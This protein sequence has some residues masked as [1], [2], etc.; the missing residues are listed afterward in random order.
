[1]LPQDQWDLGGDQE[2]ALGQ[3]SAAA[4]AAQPFLPTREQ[5]RQ[6]SVGPGVQ[7]D[8]VLATDIRRREEQFDR[9][10]ESILSG[11]HLDSVPQDREEFLQQLHGALQPQEEFRGGQLAAYAPVWQRLAA[12]TPPGE[13]AERANKVLRWMQQGAPLQFVDAHDKGKQHEPNHMRK[14]AGVARALAQAGYSPGQVETAMAGDFP[15]P[16]VLGNRLPDERSRSFAREQ[17]EKSRRLGV[18]A[19]WPEEWRRKGLRPYLLLPL[20][21]AEDAYGKRRLIFDARYLN[22]FLAYLAFCYDLLMRLLARTRRG[23][24]IVTDDLLSG[25]YQMWMHPDH[26][27]LL[28]FELDNEWFVFKC[29]PFG[30]SQCPW[31]FEQVLGAVYQLP[32]SVDWPLVGVVDDGGQT[33]PPRQLAQRSWAIAM[34]KAALG[35]VHN[36]EKSALWP[37]PALKLLGFVVDTQR[38]EL[39]V[40]ERKLARFERDVQQLMRTG[41]E[42]L[43]ASLRGQLAGF[44][45]AVRMAPLL[46]RWLQ[47]ASRGELQTTDWGSEFMQFWA[48]QLPRSNGKTWLPEQP[49]AI[50][51]DVWSDASETGYGAHALDGS[52]ELCQPFSLPE[53]CR[54]DSGGF[55]STEREVRGFLA[56]LCALARSHPGRVK[57]ADV[58][59]WG[60]SKGAVSDCRRMKGGPTVFPAVLQLYQLAFELQAQLSFVWL[61]REDERVQAADA[62]SRKPDPSDWRFSRKFAA[63]QMF[64]RAGFQHPD[65]DVFASRQAHVCPVYFSEQYDG[66]SAGVNGL[67]Q[68]WTQWPPQAERRPGRPVCFMFPP[69]HLLAQTLQKVWH[70]GAQGVLVCAADLPPGLR[71]LLRQ[72]LVRSV[73]LCGPH[74][75]MVTPTRRV[76]SE[77]RAGGWK[78]PLQGCWVEGRMFQ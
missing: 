69:P 63:E 76:P 64:N 9:A 58:Q 10:A 70:E 78:T 13:T 68:S 39:R 75:N 56:A 40:P 49:S 15:Q 7:V 28:G 48:Q 8:P 21:V 33:G 6:V 67:L 57:G 38:A 51:L 2:P 50:K 74:S 34:L 45:P 27:G 30:G 55:S 44:A 16:V 41:D 4:S 59:L 42:S 12:L 43:L 25:Y 60:D 62:L 20:A 53:Q 24:S 14:R 35:M 54:M 71:S 46:A 11:A 52:W 73:P 72:V 37:E 77:V 1:M 22:L 32:R 47:A 5:W 66:I 17:T 29:P 65:I 23:D 36:R 18:V 31:L 19:R 61:P 3:P 26:W